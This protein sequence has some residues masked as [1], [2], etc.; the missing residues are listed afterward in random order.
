MK[1][2]KFAAQWCGPCKMLSRVMEDVDLGDIQL[3]EIDID[4]NGPL[5]Q[6]WGV[7]GVPT[8]VLVGDDGKEIRRSVGL[9]N[10]SK[11]K[12]FING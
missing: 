8:M 4:Q 7:R 2:M 9:V 5:A 11:L 10:E 3:V 12:E 1:L 6:E